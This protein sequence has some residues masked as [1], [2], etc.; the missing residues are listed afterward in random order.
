MA[1]HVVTMETTDELVPLPNVD[2][3]RVTDDGKYV[4]VE[5]LIVEY[6]RVSATMA[7]RMAKRMHAKTMKRFKYIDLDG[8]GIKTPVCD[9]PT[10]LIVI[11][12]CQALAR[13]DLGN[14]P[15]DQVPGPNTFTM[16]G[17]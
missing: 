13:L 10:Q 1:Q 8:Q 14:K 17:K 5:D 7:K 15:K 12:T 6:G 11:R 16:F 2:N 3:I 4:S 9:K